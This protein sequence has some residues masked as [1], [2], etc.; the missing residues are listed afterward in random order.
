MV[1]CTETRLCAYSHGMDSLLSS[2]KQPPL[3]LALPF[4]ELPCQSHYKKRAESGLSLL[5]LC[6]R[7]MSRGGATCRGASLS[8]ML[9]GRSVL[10][11]SARQSQLHQPYSSSGS[12]C[13][14]EGTALKTPVD[15]RKNDHLLVTR[16]DHTLRPA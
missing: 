13:S 5:R 11:S 3:C 6:C 1:E 14:P 7:S 2:A 9:R 16:H 12:G 15:Y 4:S 8:D 10:K